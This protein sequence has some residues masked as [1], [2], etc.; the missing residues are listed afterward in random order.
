METI[1]HFQLSESLTHLHTLSLSLSVLEHFFRLS[2]FALSAQNPQFF[3]ILS[4]TTDLKLKL[5][6]GVQVFRLLSL[7]QIRFYGSL[8]TS[9]PQFYKLES[10]IWFVSFVLPVLIYVCCGYVSNCVTFYVSSSFNMIFEVLRIKALSNSTLCE[11]ILFIGFYSLILL[12]FL[13]IFSFDS[14]LKSN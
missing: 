3:Q 1:F 12:F 10:S 6:F 5:I 14:I 4:C 13:F 11:I 9:K 7:F 8:S 2:P